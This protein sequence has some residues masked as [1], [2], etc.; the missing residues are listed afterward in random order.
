M[1]NINNLL[2]TVRHINSITKII[3]RYITDLSSPNKSGTFHDT[4]TKKEAN[5]C[6][7]ILAFMGRKKSTNHSL[8]YQNMKTYSLR[9]TYC[10]INHEIILK[11]F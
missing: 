9:S 1:M 3:Y 6:S 8:R 5:N 2:D 4:L 11:S 10:L 7:M